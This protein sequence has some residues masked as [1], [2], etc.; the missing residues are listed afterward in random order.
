MRRRWAMSGNG[1]VPAN[2]AHR[3]EASALVDGERGLI[4]REIFTSQ[5]IYEQELER[6]FARSWL[7]LG[8]ESQVPEP[9]DYFTTTMGEDAVLVVRDETG[10]IRA[11][12][13]SCRHRW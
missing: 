10:R 2:G 11:F 12:H 6:I 8:A 7:L 4:S 3:P 13:N 1:S 9:G 5:A